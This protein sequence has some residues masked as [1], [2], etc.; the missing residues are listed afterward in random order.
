MLGRPE[1]LDGMSSVS[2]ISQGFITRTA[3]RQTKSF[4]YPIGNSAPSVACALSWCS[5]SMLVGPRWILLMTVIPEIHQIAFV[6]YD[7]D[8]VR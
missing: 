1:I 2:E 6:L 5:H 8:V 4:I 7:G 3:L